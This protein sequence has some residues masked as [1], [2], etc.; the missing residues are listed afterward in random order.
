[1]NH[2]I[3]G[4]RLTYAGYFL[5]YAGLILMLFSKHSRFGLVRKKLRRPGSVKM[6]ILLI[7]STGV[8]IIPLS[9][10][11]Q[12][13]KAVEVRKK[14]DTIIR[15]SVVAPEHARAFGSLVLQDPNGRMKPVN[16]F[17]S[18]LLR[19]INRKATYGPLNSDQVFLPMIRTGGGSPKRI[20]L[21]CRSISPIPFS[22]S[23]CCHFICRLWEQG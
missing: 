11:P 5:L 21:R 14:L 23:I 3:W 19:K 13:V 2:D 9:G 16:T 4:T 15:K 10:Q 6:V 17:T 22:L 18:E 12:V 8:S 7:F 1:V 20:L